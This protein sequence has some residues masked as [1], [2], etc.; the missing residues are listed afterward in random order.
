MAELPMV[1]TFSKLILSSGEFGCSEEI[2]TIVAMLQ[3]ESVFQTPF[4]QLA[5]KARIERRK[6]EVGEGDL[7]TLLNVFN[8]FMKSGGSKQFCNK[9]FLHYKRLKRALELRNQMMK[10]CSKL[11]IPLVSSGYDTEAVLKCITAGF[12]PNAVY[13]HY[14]GVYHTVRGDQPV[15]IHPTS[16][17]YTLP[18]PQWMVFAEI[19]HT[20]QIYVRDLTVV[21]PEWLKEA[22]PHFYTTITEKN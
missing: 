15:H 19:I 8:A 12:F 14:T 16:V 5:A 22:A 13:L 1:P 17:L 2:I 9:H 21:K 6:F 3:V 4:G 10:T 20:N 18:Q 11:D 7:I